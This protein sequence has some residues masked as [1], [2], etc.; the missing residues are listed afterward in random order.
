[1]LG[2][3]ATPIQ[4]VS[5]TK[6]VAQNRKQYCAAVNAVQPVTSA[7]I[8]VFAFHPGLNLAKVRVSRLGVRPP[9]IV[10]R[11]FVL[12]MVQMNAKMA[13]FAL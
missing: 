6:S 4:F 3:P 10:A 1:M 12:K 2:N 11:S 9:L 5:M 7:L 13:I 8:T